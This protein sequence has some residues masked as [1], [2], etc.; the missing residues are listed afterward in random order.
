MS[1]AQPTILAAVLIVGL[2][3][4]VFLFAKLK[5]ADQTQALALP[6]GSV[7]SLVALIALGLFGGL[8]FL[9]FG[10]VNEPLKPLHSLPGATIGTIEVLGRDIVAVQRGTGTDS[11]VDILNIGA[12][13]SAMDLVKQVLT[14]IGSILATIVGFYFGSRV[15][16]AAASE[17]LPAA[18][19]DAGAA[20]DPQSAISTAT[21]RFATLQAKQSELKKKAEALRPVLS[22][23]QAA[24]VAAISFAALDKATSQMAALKQRLNGHAEQAKTAAAAKD[25]AALYKAVSEARATVRA[26]QIVVAEVEDAVS[27]L[28]LLSGMT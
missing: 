5:L 18:P 23:G 21:T 13:Q 10:W 3:T 19:Q 4:L 17:A 6:A 8:S 12:A 16:T 22:S 26:A 7:R 25:H 14:T 20:L 1:I 24:P 27:R 9:T 2:G 11:T 15:A 28:Q